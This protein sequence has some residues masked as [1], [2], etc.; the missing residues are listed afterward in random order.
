MEII[1]AVLTVGLLGLLFGL[2]LFY[3]LKV[4]QVKPDPAVERISKLLPGANCGACGFGSCRMY[5]EDLASGEAKTADLC[6]PAGEE[7]RKKIAEV[8]GL[9]H[10]EKIKEIAVVHCG[11]DR[12]QRKKAAEY[13]GMENCA[14]A[15]LTL[16]GGL[17][18]SYA[19]LGYGDCMEACPF[20]AIRMEK[21]LPVIDPDKC[22][23]CG[24][25]AEA[26]PREIISLEPFIS[27][28]VTA[29]LC[30][31]K[32]TGKKV[33]QI[34]PVGCIACRICE[35]FTSGDFKVR[36]N[37][38]FVDKDKAGAGTDWHTAIQKC[39]MKTIRKVA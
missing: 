11:A 26:C 28:Q 16:N 27:G 17:A 5:A 9:E 36:D 23:A 6:K 24:K 20:G 32:D 21:G 1:Q 35:K 10:G 39:P 38:A 22:T 7:V 14:S 15:N 30:S 34:C 33:R 37:L 18:C 29:V 4:F 31:S 2:G 25:C 8:A 19:C 13:G 3:A 12:D